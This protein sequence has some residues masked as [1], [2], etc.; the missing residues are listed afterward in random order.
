[1]KVLINSETNII[2]FKRM[3]KSIVDARTGKLPTMGEHK[4]EF[5]RT[6]GVRIEYGPSG[7]F[8]EFMEFPDEQAYTMAVLKWL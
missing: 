3:N 5:E 8:W 6:H 4:A 2:L 7:N 1:M